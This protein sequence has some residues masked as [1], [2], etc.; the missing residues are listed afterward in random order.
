[1]LR[2]RLALANLNRTVVIDCPQFNIP[3]IMKKFPPGKTELGR[4]Y[5]CINCDMIYIYIGRCGTC[6]ISVFTCQRQLNFQISN[7]KLSKGFQYFKNFN[8]QDL[9]VKSVLLMIL[10]QYVDKLNFSFSICFQLPAKCC[11]LTMNRHHV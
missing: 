6:G 9:V 5:H 2:I 10:R 1:M 3:W 4:F 8:C 11:G 7:E